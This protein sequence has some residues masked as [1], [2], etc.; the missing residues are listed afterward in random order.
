MTANEVYETSIDKWRNNKG[1]GTLSYAS[2]LDLFTP[3]KMILTKYF[4][5]NPKSKVLVI[6]A[7]AAR[8][9]EWAHHLVVNFAY[10]SKIAEDLLQFVTVDSIIVNKLNETVE[11]VVFDQIDRFLYGDRRKVLKGDYIKFK[12]ILGVTNSPDP[13][14]DTFDLYEHCPVIDRITLVDVVTHGLMDGI[15]EYNIGV[16]LPNRDKTLLEEYNEFIRSTLEIFDGSFPLISLCYRGDPDKGISADH[17][18]Q[19]LAASKGWSINIDTSSQ[20]FSS[21]DRYYNPNSIYERAKSF[22][23]IIHKRQLLLS[24]NDAKLEAIVKIVDQYK[25]KKILIINKRGPFAKKV[26][27]TLNAKIKLEDLKQDRVQPTLFNNQPVGFT[28]SPSSIC[29]EYHPDV[30]SRPLVDIETND[31]FRYKSGANAGKVK[32]FGVTSLNRIA[33]ERFNE[34]YHNVISASN[35]IPKEADLTIDF[36]IITSSDCDTLNQFQYRVHRLLFKENVKIIN[37]YTEDTKELDKFSEKQSLNRN[38]VVNLN[39]SDINTVN[40]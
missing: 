27:D 13:D 30:E 19:E 18:R 33:N 21:I 37:L 15:V 1:R 35:A 5:H 40:F 4:A 31:Y 29:V 12:Y 3:V 23:D 38:K 14:D 36:I 2:N 26:S 11:L 24:D 39:I 28:L 17:Y 16:N 25:T 7:D 6:I 22:Y 8:R 20:Y 10:T 34:G 32:Q 9:E